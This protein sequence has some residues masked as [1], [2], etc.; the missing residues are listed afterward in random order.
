MKSIK[1][2]CFCINSLKNKSHKNSKINKKT[3]ICTIDTFIFFEKHNN[4]NFFMT[5]EKGFPFQSTCFHCRFAVAQSQPSCAS[6]AK[7]SSQNQYGYLSVQGHSYL[8]IT[9]RNQVAFHSNPQKIFCINKIR[10]SLLILWMIVMTSHLSTFKIKAYSFFKNRYNWCNSPT[11]SVK[12]NELT[13]L[14]H[15]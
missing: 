14:Q 13:L 15:G 7:L 5:S 8:A 10:C 12:D 11:A 6:V 1:L 3:S 4:K 2:H 9:R